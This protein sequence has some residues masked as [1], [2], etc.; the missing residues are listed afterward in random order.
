M[1]FGRAFS[2]IQEDS[3]WLKK[4]GIAGLIFMIPLLGP[5][6]VTGWGLEL[7]RRVIR[8]EPEVLPDWTNFSDFIMLGLKAWAIG[9]VLNLPGVL[10]SICQGTF[11]ALATNP[12]LLQNMDSSAVSALT[13]GV[14]VIGICCGC[15]G[16][17]LNLAATFILPAALGNMMANNGELGAAFRFNE[18]IALVRAA[19]GPYL[20]TLLGTI[21]VGII[22]P[23]GLLAC[24]IGI[25]PLLAWG[26]T[27][28][29]HLYGQAYNAAKAAQAA[30]AL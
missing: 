18:I 27:V 14:G 9:F 15:L 5:I 28:T 25:F 26:V 24:I 23:F 11:N 8:H 16:F 1:E 21:V 10:I 2:Y 12:D 3:D 20:M 17:I 13:A 19:V 4:V 22:A 30:P 29:S 6:T 7:T